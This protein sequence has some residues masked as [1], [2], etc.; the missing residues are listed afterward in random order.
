MGRGRTGGKRG[1]Q[2]VAAERTRHPYRKYSQSEIL[3]D[4]RLAIN[5]PS[6]VGVFY[7]IGKHES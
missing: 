1:K 4:I 5:E 2:V 7:E 3:R 6:T